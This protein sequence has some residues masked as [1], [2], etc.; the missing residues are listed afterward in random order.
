MNQ[1]LN[2]DLVPLKVHRKIVPAFEQKSVF[3]STE[4]INNMVYQPGTI[5]N[6]TEHKYLYLLE[7]NV[8]RIVRKKHFST[9]HI[10]VKFNLL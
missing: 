1:E 4:I 3:T 9:I 7:D 10:G 8:Q 5:Q 2:L 6:N